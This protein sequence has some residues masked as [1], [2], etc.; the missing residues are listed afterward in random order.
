MGIPA[1]VPNPYPAMQGSGASGNVPMLGGSAIVH[2]I[3]GTTGPTVAPTSGPAFTNPFASPTSAVPGT[4]TVPLTPGNGIN[5]NDGS[6][7]VT[8]DFKDTYGAGTGTAITDV[9]KNLG[10]STDAAVQATEAE[11]NREAGIQLGN[12]QASNAASGITPNSSAEQLAETNFEGNVNTS[13]QSTIA[14]LENTQESELLSTLVNEGQAHGGDTSGWD[15]FL[16]SLPLIGSAIGTGANALN[17]T[18]M[19]GTGT[20]SDILSALG[21]LA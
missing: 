2:Q 3:P 17:A 7:T 11:T 6:H 21:A 4:P 19:S 5:W 15:S 14:N 12:I 18:A 10:T 1:V 9:L 8:G 13:L 16:Q 20:F